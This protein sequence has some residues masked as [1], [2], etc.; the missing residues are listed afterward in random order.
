M[1]LS[2]IQNGEDRVIAY[3]SRTL[4]KSQ[5]RYCTTYRELLAVITFIKLF[6]HYFWGRKFVV[7]SDHS[8]LK[9]LRNLKNSEGMIARWLTVLSTYAFSNE[10][11]RD[12]LHTNADSMSRKTHRI[13]KNPSC[14]DC[15]NLVKACEKV[16]KEVPMQTNTQIL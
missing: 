16:P 10:F 3:A 7:M 4:S 14:S 11:R 2:Q 12:S 8:S 5:Q 1:V 15:V 13:C 6:R 9:W